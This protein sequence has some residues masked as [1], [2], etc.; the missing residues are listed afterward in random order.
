MGYHSSLC[1]EL[2]FVPDIAQVTLPVV[3]FRGIWLGVEIPLEQF[4][5][6]MKN[7]FKGRTNPVGTEITLVFSLYHNHHTW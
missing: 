6:I 7:T 3:A 4:S 5:I 1:G 2:S